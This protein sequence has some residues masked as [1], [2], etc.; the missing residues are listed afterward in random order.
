MEIV[1]ATVMLS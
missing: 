1:A